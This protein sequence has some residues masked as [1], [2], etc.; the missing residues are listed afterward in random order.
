M[1]DNIQMDISC[2]WILKFSSSSYKIKNYKLKL[3]V[4]KKQKP[5]EIEK[6]CSSDPHF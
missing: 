4:T 3:R 6:F 1:K 2:Q 5:K